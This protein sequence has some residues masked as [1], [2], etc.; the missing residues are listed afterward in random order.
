[1][2][3]SGCYNA[4]DNGMFKSTDPVPPERQPSDG[5]F[6]LL[7]EDNGRGMDPNEL[8]QCMSLSYPAKS[9]IADTIEPC[10]LEKLAEENSINHF[11]L[12]QDQGTRTFIYDIRE[13]KNGLLELDFD[14]DSDDIQ[15]RGSCAA[16]LS[17]PSGFQIIL[18]AKDVE[19]H[20]IVDDMIT[21]QIKRDKGINGIIGATYVVGFVKDARAHF[22]DQ[23][24][25]VYYKNRLIKSCWGVWQPA[26]RDYA[27][28]IGVLEID[29]QP[30]T[31]WTTI[32]SAI[33]YRIMKL[34]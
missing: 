2:D 5:M 12:I 7:I 23:G 4:R 3:F 28:V 9:S 31:E 19:H 10:R 20:E 21:T 26:D 17:I 30:A 22:D 24:F 1:M 6:L 25:T 14:R 15:I 34:Q 29:V 16:I 27:G 33:E 32:L 11:N 8:R 13:D 18:R